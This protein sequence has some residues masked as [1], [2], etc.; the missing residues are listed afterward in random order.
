MK[1]ADKLGARYAVILGEDEIASGTA[2]I[3]D[4]ASSDQRT[5]PIAEL[6]SALRGV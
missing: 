2:T 4:M 6:P 1:T 3:R 5:V